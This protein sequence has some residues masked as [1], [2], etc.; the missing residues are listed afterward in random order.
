MSEVFKVCVES[1]EISNFGNVRIKL[2]NGEYKTLK[3]SILNRGGGY[4]YFQ[5]NRNGKRK[6][7]FV[8]HLVA[9]H[10]IGARPNNLVIDHIDRNPLNNNVSNL[11][12]VSQKENVHNSKNFIDEIN[13]DDPNK[14]HSIICKRYRDARKDQ[15]ESQKKQPFKCECGSTVRT[16]GKI[17][18][19][20]S[21]KHFEFTK[22]KQNQKSV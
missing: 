21:K 17:C 12:Y 5:L 18:H 19:L 16:D 15:I 8:H 9:E 7:F 1:Y 20:R 22:K 6:N 14:R 3:C 11:R 13:E 2:K 4:K 10:F